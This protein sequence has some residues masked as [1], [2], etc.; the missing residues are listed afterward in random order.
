M[1]RRRRITLEE[2]L[3]I[4]PD[5]EDGA[6]RLLRA[7]RNSRPPADASADTAQRRTFTDAVRERLEAKRL[8][9]DDLTPDDPDDAA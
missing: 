1:S 9:W 8:G 7:L 2:S 4:A 5:V 3:G 6:D